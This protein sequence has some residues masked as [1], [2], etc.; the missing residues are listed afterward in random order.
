MSTTYNPISEPSSHP[1]QWQAGTRMVMVSNGNAQLVESD[2][3]SKFNIERFI[4]QISRIYIGVASLLLITIFVLF[5][6]IFSLSII[7]ILLLAIFLTINNRNHPIASKIIGPSPEYFLVDVSV[8]SIKDEQRIQ[9]AETGVYAVV[10]IGYRVS[11]VDPVGVV[12][13]GVT[14]VR[15]YL[16]QKIHAEVKQQSLGGTLV[17]KVMALRRNLDSTAETLSGSAFEPL[18]HI[19]APT[20]DVRAEG[21]V[22]EG[23]SKIAS[24]ELERQVREAQALLN[25]TERQYY[26]ELVNNDTL[27]IAEIARPGSNKASLEQVLRAKLERSDLNYKRK[28]EF[29]RMALE[30]GVLEAH[31]ISQ[32]YPEFIKDVTE[33]MR[34]LVALPPASDG[35]TGNEIEPQQVNQR[36]LSEDSKIDDKT[37]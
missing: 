11:V 4:E 31:Q 10:D 18:F 26:E 16:S 30:N 1:P 21:A 8:H 22:G 35:N 33:T 2:H 5:G 24:T 28:V 34:N 13:A 23:L 36:E 14:D 12:R 3:S 6:I 15:E 25:Q 7:L 37:D 29:L 32:D 20:L 17:D 27:L 9:L 19:D